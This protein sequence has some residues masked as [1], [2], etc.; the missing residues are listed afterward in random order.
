ML[1]RGLVPGSASVPAWADDKP[2]AD[3]PRP[4]GAALERDYPAPG[5]KPSWKKPQINRTLVQDFVICAHSDPEMP[6]KLLEK[7]PML[8]NAVL[9]WGAGDWESGLAGAS[10]VG[11]REIVDVVRDRGP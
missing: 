8:I 6:R 7:E 1:G 9:D 11:R 4:E 2:D 3:A 5:F 10:H